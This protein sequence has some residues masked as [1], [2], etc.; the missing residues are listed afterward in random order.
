MTQ[1]QLYKRDDPEPSSISPTL[2]NAL[3]LVKA[4]SHGV[5]GAV[6]QE[7]AMQEIEAERDRNSGEG[8]DKQPDIYDRFP[9]SK[10]L[11]I[12]FIVSYAA[13]LGRES[14]LPHP[15]PAKT[16]TRS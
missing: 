11:L 12:L 4:I 2:S 16:L 13:F 6:D 1:P 5:E 10:K 8:E 15:S 3:P 9:K 7:K 14:V